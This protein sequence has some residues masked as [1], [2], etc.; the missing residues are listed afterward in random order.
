MID[1][2]RLS[3]RRSF[4]AQTC[5][6]VAALGAT[7][8]LFGATQS[9]PVAAL[10]IPALPFAETALEP[11]LSA[12]TFQFHYGKHHQGYVTT[13]NKLLPSTPF[14]NDALPDIVRKSWKQPQFTAVFNNAAQIWNHTFYWNSLT[15]AATQKKPSGKIEQALMQS[16]GSMQKFE[17]AFLEAALTQ[18]GSGWAWLVAEGD[19]LSVIKTPNAETPLTTPNLR[20]LLV[21]D[22]WE[23]AYYLDYQNR[24]ADYVKAIIAQHL[25]WDFAAK[26]LVAC[27]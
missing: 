20:P 24:R 25:N 13:L 22:V 17:A 6:T 10:S 7:P 11:T 12:K 27:C 5:G 8:T 15:P 26:N 19:K 4:L 16:F 3:S 1:S 14:A 18:F 9:A 21:I 23:H 2:T